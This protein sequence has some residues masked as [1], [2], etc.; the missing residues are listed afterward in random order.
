MLFAKPKPQPNPNPWTQIVVAIAAALTFA[1]GCFTYFH[2]RLEKR[3]DSIDDNLA[4]VREGL[5][6]VKA[7]EQRNREDIAD[8]RDARNP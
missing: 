4:G 5:V 7:L 6:E 3:L 1:F 8:L 2:G